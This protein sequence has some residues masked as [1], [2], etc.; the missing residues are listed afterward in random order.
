MAELRQEAGP[1]LTRRLS[2][3]DVADLLERHGLAPRKQAGQNFVGDP[4][5]VEAVL[6]SALVVVLLSGVTFDS[7]YTQRAPLT[8]AFLTWCCILI[9]FGSVVYMTWVVVDEVRTG[10][11]ATFIA[12]PWSRLKEPIG[13]ALDR[14]IDG[15]EIVKT[16][17]RTAKVGLRLRPLLQRRVEP[18]ALHVG[19]LQRC[20]IRLHT[21]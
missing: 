16:R 14:G 2:P 1:A 18:R 4:N 9:I 15:V 10:G 5:T 12:H 21:R 6:L 13:K 3:A 20:R 8:K 7:P 11:G 19:A 17:D